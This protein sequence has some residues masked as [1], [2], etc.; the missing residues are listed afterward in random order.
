MRLDSVRKER[1][2]SNPINSER[3]PV[4]TASPILK[5]V[6]P[7]VCM[8]VFYC[9]LTVRIQQVTFTRNVLF[10]HILVVGQL[11]GRTPESGSKVQTT[12]PILK[13]E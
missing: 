11:R 6:V 4:S 10:S 7:R 1:D 8:L 2:V 13:Y 12:T 5:D 9:A 3:C